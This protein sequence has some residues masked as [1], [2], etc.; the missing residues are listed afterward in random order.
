MYV[1]TSAHTVCMYVCGMNA[2]LHE[3]NVSVHEFSAMCLKYAEL[4][5]KL[6]EIDRARAVYVHGSQMSDPRVSDHLVVSP[7]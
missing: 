6:G 2:I 4:E 3:L 1:T 7:V 5:A